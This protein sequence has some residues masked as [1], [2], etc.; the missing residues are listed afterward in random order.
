M[1]KYKGSTNISNISLSALP[2]SNLATKNAPI[3]PYDYSK[4]YDI[5]YQST[6]FMSLDRSDS[7]KEDR[8]DKTYDYYPKAGEKIPR[9]FAER[10]I[11][12]CFHLDPY[13]LHKALPSDIPDMTLVCES[14]IPQKGNPKPFSL[15]TLK[16]QSFRF[17]IF[18]A[19]IKYISQRMTEKP[20]RKKEPFIFEF[21]E[22]F[23][24][25]SSDKEKALAVGYLLKT[26]H[27][28][29]IVF[30]YTWDKINPNDN[31]EFSPIH[32]LDH[33]FVE[34]VF[35]KLWYMFAV[36]HKA[37]NEKGKSHPDFDVQSDFFY[38]F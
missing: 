21:V 14:C 1:S 7:M 32:H 26:P 20:Y 31:G 27:L 6:D 29:P 8:S 30:Q 19:G 33:I 22:F 16:N 17:E 13:S 9:I 15:R 2:L 37:K 28:R 3:G 36:W 24:A 25:R 18:K 4:M 34:L 38:L 5:S 35:D 23:N 12:T 11:I 10:R